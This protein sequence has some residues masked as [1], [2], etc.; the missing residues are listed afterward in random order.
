MATST[1][2]NR[3]SPNHGKRSTRVNS[4][5]R[6]LS[7]CIICWSAT[8]WISSHLVQVIVRPRTRPRIRGRN[9]SRTSKRTGG[10]SSPS[11]S[12]TRMACHSRSPLN[13]CKKVG[14]CSQRAY[15]V[16]PAV[17][18]HCP[19]VDELYRGARSNDTVHR[20][21]YFDQSSFT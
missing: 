12:E 14:K 10:V 15:L 18:R 2:V 4:H 1:D 21:P 13:G 6:F 3:L 11:T 5:T 17:C 20:F 7:P 8:T 16:L 19:S 9:C